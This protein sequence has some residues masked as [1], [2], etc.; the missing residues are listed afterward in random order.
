MSLLADNTT[1]WLHWH[2]IMPDNA[3][4]VMTLLAKS[5]RLHSKNL[6]LL[7]DKLGTNHSAADLK[8]WKQ[9]AFLQFFW[10]LPPHAG[11]FFQM[12]P[13]ACAS[14][15]GVGWSLDSVCS[16]EDVKFD[17]CQLHAERVAEWQRSTFLSGENKKRVPMA[18]CSKRITKS[19]KRANLIGLI[20]SA[21]GQSLVPWLIL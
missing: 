11:S 2:H 3:P 15:W 4:F 8:R 16:R 17:F 7:K 14:S 1:N 12:E 10:R 5:P 6:A 9:D 18:M 20:G 21:Y 13:H 19:Q